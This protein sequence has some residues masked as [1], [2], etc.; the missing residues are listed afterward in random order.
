MIED[1]AIMVEDKLG[2]GKE[3][4]SMEISSAGEAVRWEGV[5]EEGS[6]KLKN[7]HT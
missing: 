1:V 7:T 5:Y 6:F 2:E 4:E 3:D